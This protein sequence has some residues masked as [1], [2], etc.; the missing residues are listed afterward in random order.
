MLHIVSCR[1][2]YVI[3]ARTADAVSQPKLGGVVFSLEWLL[4]I[5]GGRWISMGGPVEAGPGSPFRTVHVSAPAGAYAIELVALP[6]RD[7][8]LFSAG[9]CN[10]A[11]W[12]LFHGAPDRCTFIEEEWAHYLRVNRIFADVTR[13]TTAPD[14]V[15]WIHDFQF[16]MI[17]HYLRHH[18][19]DDPLLF[20]WHIPFPGLEIVCRLPWIKKLVEGLLAYDTIGFH[21]RRYLNNFIDAAAFFLGARTDPQGLSIA[22]DGRRVNLVAE[23]VGI[24]FDA[25]QSKAASCSAERGPG[26]DPD[27]VFLGVDRQDHAKGI[28]EK[29]RAFR[30]L[31]DRH[32]DLLGK[33][34]LVQIAAPSRRDTT[35][36]RVLGRE[37][38]S[39]AVNINR[40][41]ATPRHATV[42]IVEECIDRTSLISYYRSAD[43]LIVNSLADGL[44]LVSLEY[45]AARGDERG[46]LLLSRNTG[47]ADYLKS[48]ALLINPRDQEAVAMQM[49][50]AFDMEDIER[51]ARMQRLRRIARTLSLHRW[52]A[53]MLKHVPTT[54]RRAAWIGASTISGA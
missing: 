35:G 21:T 26:I 44:N 1:S 4:S 48:G 34:R 5:H 14:D 24:D 49:R 11:L 30:V 29:L 41:Y 6:E 32:P 40:D 53:A 38:R 31:L 36:Y 25:F 51:R 50:R 3:A 43:A 42:E 33:V 8:R 10:R 23:P 19:H 52:S 46:V 54:P 2:P 37:I 28:L 20:F 22:I 13:T 45:I 47:V 9:F 7:V 39:L 27:F 17:G 16:A 15:V 12:P 18:H